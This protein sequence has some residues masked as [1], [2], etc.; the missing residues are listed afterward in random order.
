MLEQE[1]EIEVFKK[2][3]L[4]CARRGPSARVRDTKDRAQQIQVSKDFA[5]IFDDEED[6]LLEA[7]QGN[8]PTMHIPKTQAKHR[9]PKKRFATKP[10]GKAPPRKAKKKEEKC[11]ESALEAKLE[12]VMEVTDSELSTGWENKIDNP[13]MVVAPSWR[14]MKCRGCKQPI[15]QQDKEFPHSFVIHRR[16]VVSYFNKLHKLTVSRTFTSIS[17]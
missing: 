1:K 11:N 17:A 16:G 3:L 15:T 7:T 13:P 5:N 6:V 12:L 2:N 9:A 8:N 4:K 14:I 10:P